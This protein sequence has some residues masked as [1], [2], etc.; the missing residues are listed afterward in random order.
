MKDNNFRQEKL[1]LALL[2]VCLALA[3]VVLPPTQAFDNKRVAQ[4]CL[5]QA[6]VAMHHKENRKALALLEHAAKLDPSNSNVQLCMGQINFALDLKQEA[7]KNLNEGLRLDPDCKNERSYM[8]LGHALIIEDRAPEAIA[9]F[10]KGIAKIPGSCDLLC[11]R[12]CT[13]ALIDQYTKG[14]IDLDGAIK[15]RPSSSHYYKERAMIFS[16]MHQYANAIKDLT[17]WINIDPTSSLAYADR[18]RA[19]KVL[20]KMDLAAKDMEKSM[21]LSVIDKETAKY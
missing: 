15:L 18:A 8:L 20:G 6:L 1:K 13:Y 12:G 17:A 7:I 3:L 11:E 14:K 2:L 4:N 5:N 16:G 10:T 21:S 19:Y 9:A